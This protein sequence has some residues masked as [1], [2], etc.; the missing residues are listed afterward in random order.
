MGLAFVL[1][2]TATISTKQNRE[3]AAEEV[4][5][6]LQISDVGITTF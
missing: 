4:R 3:F 1:R 5:L 2:P 6:Q